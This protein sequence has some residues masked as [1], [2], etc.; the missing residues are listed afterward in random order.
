[1][2]TSSLLGLIGLSQL[3]TGV[4][5]Q[6]DVRAVSGGVVF[7]CAL[8]IVIRRV[9]ATAQLREAAETRPRLP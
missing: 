4:I 5:D 2:I 1:M 3:V 6:N 8:L 9:R 7:G